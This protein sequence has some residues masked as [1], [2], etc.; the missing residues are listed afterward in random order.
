MYG[1]T[2]LTRALLPLLEKSKT[3]KVVNVSPGLGSI[4]LHSDLAADPWAALAYE[5]YGMSK[6]AFN[7]PSA[8]H[9]TQLKKFSAK[10]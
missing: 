4:G 10:T 9:S 5:P 2:L 8:C 7:M 6:W 3:L 1:S